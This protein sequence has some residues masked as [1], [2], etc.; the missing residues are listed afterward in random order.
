M[1][2]RGLVPRVLEY[3]FASIA[4]QCDVRL[5]TI[6]LMWLVASLRHSLLLECRLPT[7]LAS[8]CNSCARLR[9]WR[10][11]TRRC[12]TSWTPLPVAC[13]RPLVTI[14]TTC[15]HLFLLPCTLLTVWSL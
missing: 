14:T 11:T 10:S 2:Q 1:E 7:S 15:P 12:L 3:L 4:D 8:H 13:V 6:C 9:S 5:L